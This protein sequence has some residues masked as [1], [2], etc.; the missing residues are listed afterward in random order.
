MPEVDKGR[1]FSVQLID[2]YTFN[3]AYIGSRATGNRGGRYMV[4]GPSWQGEP[5]EGITKV[6][7]CET[8]F[9]LAI[10]RTQ[11]FGPD[12]L[13]NVNKVQAGYQRSPS[14]PSS[15]VP[16]H[17]SRPRSSGPGSTRHRPTPTHSPT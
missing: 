14:R 12:D 10:Y 15:T 2:L 7:R 6:L 11:L 3:Y 8:D 4:A 1:Y 16:P 9:S 5:P 17:P 13:E